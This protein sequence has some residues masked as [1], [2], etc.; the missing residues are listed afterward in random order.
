MF[1]HIATDA[2]NWQAG[3]VRCSNQ[4][5]LVTYM[6]SKIVR[7]MDCCDGFSNYSVLSNIIFNDM[8]KAE[9]HFDVKT[10]ET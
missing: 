10:T 6:S 8:Q 5:E 3:T 4:G 7:C 2:L 9:L 1:P